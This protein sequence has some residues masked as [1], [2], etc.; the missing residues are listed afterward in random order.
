MTQQHII[1][2][3]DTDCG[4]TWVTTQL[5]TALQQ[6]TPCIALKPIACGDDDAGNH[7]DVVHLLQAQSLQQASR[8]NL[9]HFSLP[10]APAIAAA[11]E[12]TCIDIHELTRWCHQ[13]TSGVTLIEGIGGLMV[14]IT[15]Q[16]TG[17][18]WIQAMPDAS[19]ILVVGVR[20]GCIN[21]TLLTLKALHS[22]GRTPDWLIINALHNT[23]T[24]PHIDA[25]VNSIRPHAQH[26]HIITCYKHHANSLNPIINSLVK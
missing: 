19:I 14:P 23:Q 5:I 24:N 3:T 6:H 10:A 16:Q 22:I 17:L 13:Q 18:D 9:H 1:I 8:I 4:K 12:N 26:S 20:L 2:G 11:H 15:M 25:T 21:H 7:P